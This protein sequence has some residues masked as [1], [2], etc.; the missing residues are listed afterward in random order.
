MSSVEI[1]GH[2][3]LR[4]GRDESLFRPMTSYRPGSARRRDQRPAAAVA[5]RGADAVGDVDP[6]A[7]RIRRLS[8][9]AGGDAGTGRASWSGI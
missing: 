7:A 4:M 8:A 1:V 6:R 3:L 5:A 9:S 2:Q